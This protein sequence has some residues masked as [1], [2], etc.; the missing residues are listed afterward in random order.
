M[1]LV[2]GGGSKKNWR[3]LKSRPPIFFG[4]PLPPLGNSVRS[5]SATL[6]TLRC[7]CDVCY[8]DVA[9]DVTVSS[10][11]LSLN[12]NTSS[13]DSEFVR[14][15]EHWEN[16]HL[17]RRVLNIIGFA[18]DG[19]HTVR[20]KG[21]V[22]HQGVARSGPANSL[23]FTMHS[24]LLKSSKCI[25]NAQTRKFGWLERALVTTAL[26]LFR[27]AHFR[28]QSL[29]VARARE[30]SCFG[31]PKST[32]RD[33]RKQSPKCNVAGAAFSEP[34]CAAESIITH[35][36]SQTHSHTHTHSRSLTH[37]LSH[38][39]THSLHFPNAQRRVPVWLGVW[40]CVCMACVASSSLVVCRCLSLSLVV[41]RRRRR[42]VSNL[43]WGKLLRVTLHGCVTCPFAPL[44]HCDLRDTDMSRKKRDA[45]RCTGAAFCEIR[46][47]RRSS[48]G[49]SVWRV[50]WGVGCG[51]AIGICVSG[52]G[53]EA[54]FS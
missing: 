26:S 11:I 42:H 8:C 44:F 22:P 2:S 30:T 14:R 23:L 46:R 53:I 24:C 36:H 47:L 25:S 41:S 7:L 10:C 18:T 19:V 48:I 43:H 6:A 9:R 37:S 16:R 12:K 39:L 54:L 34:Q 35:T 1:L 51:R 13:I 40:T 33:N 29:F 32:F 17:Q 52:C 50:V 5:M 45:L 3:C 21:P 38:S 27:R 49:I 28:T 20:V 4:R 15:L 31:G